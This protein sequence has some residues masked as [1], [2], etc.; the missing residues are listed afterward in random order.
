MAIT[1][2]FHYVY[3]KKHIH[4]HLHGCEYHIGEENYEEKYTE[5]MVMNW[6][7]DY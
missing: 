5:V 3:G 4:T 7:L 6:T 1:I 2:Y